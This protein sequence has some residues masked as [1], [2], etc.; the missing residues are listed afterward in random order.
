VE[1]VIASH[2][3]VFDVAVIGVEDTKWT[4]AVTAVVIPREGHTITEG[5]LIEYTRERLA[6][7]K[8]PKKIV[9]IDAEE[10]PRT[11]TGKI[12]HRVLRERFS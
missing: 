7:F 12:L 11:G 3:E 5:D 9:F 10:M 6:H 4:E 2:S 8:C 1:T